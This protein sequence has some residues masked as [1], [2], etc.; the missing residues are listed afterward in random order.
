MEMK[1]DFG[2]QLQQEQK[3]IMTQELQLAVKIL[4]LTSYELNEYIEEQL[5]ENPLLESEDK[6]RDEEHV[7]LQ[8][9]ISYGAD[10]KDYYRD[11]SEDED[12]SPINFV[13]QTTSLWDHLKEQLNLIPISLKYREVGEYIIDNIDEYGYLTVDKEDISLKFNITVEESENIISLIQNLEPA[14]ICSRSINECL[15][16]QVKSR[17]LHDAVFENIINNML[18]DVAR[19]KIAAIS[20]ENDIT[21]E[22]AQSYI[23][24][25]KSLDPKPGIR[26]SNETTRY[27]IPDVIVEKVDNE[28]VVS[29]ND[30]FIPKIKI[31]NT[32]KRILNDKDS[33]GYNFVKERLNAAIWLIKSIE[34]RMSTIKR[35]VE[36]I[37]KH[38]YNFFESDLDLRPLTLKQIAKETNL[39]ESTI[40]RAIKGKYVQTPKG[41]FEI[42]N[43]FLRGIQSQ[44]GEEI[45]TIKI[46][47]RIKQIIDDE[48]KLKPYSDQHISEMIS[49]EGFDISRRTVAKYRE[50]MDILSSSKRK[51]IK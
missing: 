51:V 22:E 34:Q 12:I 26:F 37:I 31:N 47:Q 3:L 30:E 45:G 36:S 32:Y 49:K 17:G 42:K 25:I 13:S 40:S 48:N 38:Q 16:L 41:L 18:E 15:L 5:I 43:F 29:I 11:D 44:S 7:R 1:L 50:E 23:N 21:I 14:G 46:K 33:S 27:I 9:L 35:V 2:L 19:G 28:Y 4:Q 20:K 24:V 8:N 39:H 6:G 10:D